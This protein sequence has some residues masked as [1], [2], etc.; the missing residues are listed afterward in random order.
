M[1]ETKLCRGCS[2]EKPIT[3]FHLHKGKP[4]SRCKE[5]RR[6]ERIDYSLR[7]EVVQRSKDY[8]QEHKVEF[9]DRMRDYYHSLV[10]QY[11]QYKK[12]AVKSNFE[13]TITKED[14]K[15]FYR[16]DCYYCGGLIKDLGI[17]RIDNSIGYVLSNCVPCCSVCNF[18][19][20]TLA[21]DEFIYQIQR[22]L[23]IHN[24]N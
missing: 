5:C 1:C 18:M 22:I 24:I 13:F 12:R 8:Y 3:E 20:G 14:C 10:G 23:K 15:A 9:R 2:I 4:R 11:H 6:L 16:T 17:D 19:K 21:K 7:P